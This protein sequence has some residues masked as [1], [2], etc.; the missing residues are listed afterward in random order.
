MSGNLNR[1]FSKEDIQMVNKHMKRSSTSLIIK[2]TQIKTAMRYHLVS[3][4]M[5]TIKK[6]LQIVNDGEKVE[7]RN[8][9]AV[10]ADCK[11]IQPLRRTVGNFLKKK[12]KP[13]TRNKTITMAQQGASLV[14]QTI[15]NLPAMWETWVPS[16]GREDP[17]EEEMATHSSILAW[18]TP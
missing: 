8:P 5:A 11:L 6:N 13:K 1:H 2:E 7:K 3:V 14:A 12:K 9:V 17:L 18:K 15:K 4:R 10:L 16:L